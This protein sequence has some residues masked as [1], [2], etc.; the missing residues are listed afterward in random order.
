MRDN[1]GNRGESAR[2][3]P[4][5]GDRRSDL[6]DTHGGTFDDHDAEGGRQGDQVRE[7][8]TAHE[9]AQWGADVRSE[10]LPPVK[11]PLPAGLEH[12]KGP[13][14]KTIGRHRINPKPT[15]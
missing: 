13:M 5:N 11:E 12:R 1:S 7:D 2:G 9:D 15:K 4:Q 8:R 6:R 14:N 3:L 10:P